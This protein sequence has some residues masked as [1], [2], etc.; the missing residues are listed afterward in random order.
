MFAVRVFVARHVLKN[1]K[2]KVNS[3]L[4]VV[5]VKLSCTMRSPVNVETG[6]VI[7]FVNREKTSANT[8]I[9][10]QYIRVS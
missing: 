1:P 5:L 6:D 3:L 10:L 8:V 4:S 9:S 2:A 7:G